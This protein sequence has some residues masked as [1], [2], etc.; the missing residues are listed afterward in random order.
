MSRRKESLDADFIT[1]RAPSN[2][3]REDEESAP[4]LS[5]LQDNSLIQNP[6]PYWPRNREMGWLIPY[7]L[8]YPPP[9]LPPSLR[10]LQ[11]D[12]AWMEVER[13]HVIVN[14]VN[15]LSSS[16]AILITSSGGIT[17]AMAN[18]KSG[19]IWSTV[20]G[21]L[22]TFAGTVLGGIRAS[23]QPRRAEDRVR[24]LERI[25]DHIGRLFYSD[26]KDGQPPGK[27]VEETWKMI[28]EEEAQTEREERNSKSTFDYLNRTNGGS[29]TGNRELD[30]PN[31]TSAIDDRTYFVERHPTQ[32][33][34]G[35]KLLGKERPSRLTNRQTSL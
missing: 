12:L 35:S 10:G 32:K 9:T 20:M 14:R 17:A 2:L 30:D 15:L 29:T 16:L 3:M 5:N 25:I 22:T 13:Q 34:K 28:D 6:T 26:D 27:A 8:K 7:G 24:R 19:R 1:S 23:G 33:R 18:S 31:C 4:L 21:T 11:A